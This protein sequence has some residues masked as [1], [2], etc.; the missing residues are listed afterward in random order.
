ML[1]SENFLLVFLEKLK[2]KDS[3]APMSPD[4]ICLAGAWIMD[5]ILRGKL[6]IEG[7]SL[8][9]INTSSTGDEY[10]DEI[11]AIIKDSKRK[12]KLNRWVD[13][14]SSK[15]N[16]QIHSSALKRLQSQGILTFKEN[17]VAKIFYK[18]DYILARPEIVQSLLEQIQKVFIENIDPNIELLCLLSLLRLNKSIKVCIAKEYRKYAK[19]RY[20]ELIHSDKYEPNHIEMILKIKK[21]FKSTYSGR[22]MVFI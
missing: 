22:N 18:W 12:H 8:L 17:I 6:S 3:I 9:V 10:L 20:E 11:F 13:L 5:L 16:K 15:Y 2:H 1:I 19:Y 4:N 21:A 14:L 7:K